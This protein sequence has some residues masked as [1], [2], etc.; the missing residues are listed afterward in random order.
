M[1][2]YIVAK[3][4][5]EALCGT[6][7]IT[8]PQ[9]PSPLELGAKSLFRLSVTNWGNEL[10]YIPLMIRDVVDIRNMT[11]TSNKTAKGLDAFCHAYLTVPVL[12]PETTQQKKQVSS[13]EAAMSLH[14]FRRSDING[15]EIFHMHLGSPTVHIVPSCLK[16]FWNL[17]DYIDCTEKACL[18]VSTLEAIFGS[19]FLILGRVAK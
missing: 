4:Y 6:D 12:S 3:Q 11:R 10:V 9:R 2:Q 17:M 14:E 7:A 15:D 16:V 8:F 1:S 18:G 13:L 19:R 5:G